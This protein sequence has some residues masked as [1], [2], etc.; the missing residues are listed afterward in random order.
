MSKRMVCRLLWWSQCRWDGKNGLGG[1]GATFMVME[2]SWRETD[3]TTGFPEVKNR[4]D[5]VLVVV[6]TL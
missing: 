2:R 3:L 6:V 5:E 4:G 1:V